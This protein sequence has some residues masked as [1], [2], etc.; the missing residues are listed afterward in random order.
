[1]SRVERGKWKLVSSRST[2]SKRKPG[3]MKIDVVPAPAAT[4]APLSGS[5]GQRRAFE[6]PHHGGADGDDPPASRR[7]RAIAS[8]VAGGMSK[9]SGS[10]RCSCTS[11]AVTGLKVP[12]PDVQRDKGAFDAA[13]VEALQELLREVQ[14]GG[15]G[16]DRPGF[17]RPDGLI[18]LAVFR[19]VGTGDVGRQRHMPE[20]LEVRLDLDREVD[21]VAAVLVLG[22]DDRLDLRAEAKARPDSGLASGLRQAVPALRSELLDQQEL[23]GASLRPRR[24]S[25]TWPAIRRAKSRAG[26]TRVSLAI[27]RSPGRRKRGRSRMF[28][29]RPAPV[30]SSRSRRLVPR[31]AACWAI[32]LSGRSKSKSRTSIKGTTATARSMEAAGK[33]GRGRLCQRSRIELVAQP[34]ADEVEGDGRRARGR[35]RERRQ[36][37]SRR[38]A[39]SVRRRSCCPSSPPAVAARSRERRGPPR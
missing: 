16:G 24:P 34:L 31:G 17:A 13:L 18:A 38:R 1:M 11:S 21:G 27:M 6:R 15:G 35:R 7:A 10:I 20:R 36:P 9:R 3:V 26:I 25:P 37:T 14:A 12:M 4:A 30:A 19:A 8:A 28:A 39:S 22:D 29:W 5:R 23:D 32:A 33:G 2:T